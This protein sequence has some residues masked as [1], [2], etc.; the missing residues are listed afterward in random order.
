MWLSVALAMA[1][2]AP[3][4]TQQAPSHTD[5]MYGVVT[6]DDGDT[7]EGFIRWT[8]NEGS[9]SDFLNGNKR[10]DPEHRDQAREMSGRRSRGFSILGIRISFDDD[11]SDQASSGLRFGHIA[12]LE[13]QRGGRAE[14][15]LLSG[16]VVEF[17]G[18]SSDIGGGMELTVEDPMRGTV[19]VDWRDLDRVEFSDAPADAAP[20]A[21]RLYGTL[22]TQEGH[23]FTGFIAWDSDE[24]L[25]TDVLDGDEKGRDRE[26]PFA[27]IGSIQRFSSSGARITLANGEEIVLKDS[28]DVDDDN[29]GIIVA[30]P[31][32]GQVTVDWD[33]FLDVTFEPAPADAAPRSRFD[34]GR[35]LRGTVE[36]EDGRELK[37]TIRWDN[38]EEFTWEA[39]DGEAAYVEMD[40]ELGN[41]ASIERLDD[42]SAQVTLHDGRTFEMS[43]SNDVDEHN[44]GI[45]VTD[46]A[47]TVTM[48]D[49]EEFRVVRFDG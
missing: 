9:W 33:E 46:A 26:I 12:S 43:G 18:G 28:N 21:Q 17:D 42:D 24:I 38:D 36:T 14:I 23:A 7:Y 1:A 40:I 15:V 8:D 30:D 2:A 6:T 22:R 10:L 29:R 13:R 49:W 32:L 37:G 16:E 27:N 11:G 19:E 31:Q 41:V 5:R 35:R 39:L 48:L 4:Q 20:L 47:G 45:F 34:G 44:K 25:T 3:V